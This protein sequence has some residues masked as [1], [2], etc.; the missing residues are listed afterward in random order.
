MI[1]CS[2]FFYFY[3]CVSYEF[4]ILSYLLFQMKRM[5]EQKKNEVRK[6]LIKS[7]VSMVQHLQKKLPIDS[8]ILQYL[9]C[10]GPENILS[11]SS[12]SSIENLA[13][14]ISHVIDEQEVRSWF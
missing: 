7:Y 10:L 4:V 9:R 12:I 11:Q 6:T 14:L 1:S 2:I 13:K 8:K 5:S 3:F